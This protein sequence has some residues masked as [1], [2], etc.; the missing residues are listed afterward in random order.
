M[1]DI[2]EPLSNDEL[3]WLDRFI[4]YRFNEDADVEG[5]DEGVLC[6]SELDGLLTAVVSGPMISSQCLKRALL[7]EKHT[8]SLMS[9]AKVIYVVLLWLLSSGNWTQWK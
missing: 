5:K 7:M 6:V 4:I 3:D 1:K 2:F 8:L 9:G